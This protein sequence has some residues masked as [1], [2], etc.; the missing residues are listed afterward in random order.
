MKDKNTLNKT[1][2]SLFRFSL[3][4]AKYEGFAEQLILDWHPKN[5]TDSWPPFSRR[6]E[7]RY[8]LIMMRVPV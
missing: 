5:N 7:A 6:R 2:V 3:L 4:F 8:F 1:A